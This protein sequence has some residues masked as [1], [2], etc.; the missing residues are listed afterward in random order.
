MK[1]KTWTVEDHLC[2]GCG[3]RILRCATGQGMSPG[4]NALWRC[5]QCDQ[6]GS[7]LGAGGGICWCDFSHRGQNATAYRC[8]P[9]SVLEKQPEL[10]EAFGACGCDPK[11]GEVGVVLESDIRRLRPIPG[12]G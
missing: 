12:G 5:A 11:H 2:N 9:F 7:G 4:G 1:A 3:G 8:L 6:R 10:R